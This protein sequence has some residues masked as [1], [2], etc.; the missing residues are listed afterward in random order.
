MYIYICICMEHVGA[1]LPGRGG[2]NTDVGKIEYR[3]S[4]PPPCKIEI[5]GDRIDTL[6]R[7][8]YAVPLY[9]RCAKSVQLSST[10][11]RIRVYRRR[12]YRRL[13]KGFF[14]NTDFLCLGIQCVGAPTFDIRRYRYYR[15]GLPDVG[16]NVCWDIIFFRIKGVSHEILDVHFFSP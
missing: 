4:I 6:G 7:K 5:V 13:K 10:F 15:S 1:G 8:W 12:E 11:I 16:T 9:R 3:S 14:L 2:G